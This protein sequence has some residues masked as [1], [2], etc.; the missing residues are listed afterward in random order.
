MNTIDNFKSILPVAT[1]EQFPVD[2]RDLHKA[3]QIKT[4]FKDWIRR[5]LEETDAIEG[6]DFRSKLSES[7]GGR[8]SKEYDL[9]LVLAKEFAILERNT[10]GK[11]IRRYL[12]A[13]EEELSVYKKKLAEMTTEDLIIM[14]AKSVKELKAEVKEVKQ[15]QEVL[16]I[17]V[18]IHENQC[19]YLF[20]KVHQIS[21]ETGYNPRFIWRALKA[22]FGVASY[23]KLPRK[24]FDLAKTWISN[25]HDNAKKSLTA[26]DDLFSES[27]SSLR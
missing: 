11:L 16:E 25:Y 21:R 12:I 15:K 4:E 5:R 14:Q 9:T 6:K 8:P 24:Q 13:C 1:N 22:E 10:I 17:D 27:N 7:T 20:E 19:G 23:R 2:A 3:L 26:Q 18:P